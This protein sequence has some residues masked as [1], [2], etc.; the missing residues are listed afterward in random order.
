MEH[1]WYRNLVRARA[2]LLADGYRVVG[3][4]T[5]QGHTQRRW[6]LDELAGHGWRELDFLEHYFQ[7]LM[8]ENRGA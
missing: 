5:N 6:A 1:N 8:L 2:E 4:L 7:L 3:A